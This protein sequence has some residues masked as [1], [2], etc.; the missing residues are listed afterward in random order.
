MRANYLRDHPTD[1]EA[2]LAV[3][4]RKHPNLGLKPS[5]YVFG[6]I[7]DF[8]SKPL[9]LVVELDGRFHRGRESQDARRDKNLLKRGITTL[10]FPS[11]LV[12][13]DIGKIVSEIQEWV[14]AHRQ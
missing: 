5:I 12:F 4:L 6:Y 14:A 7:A 2:L 1:S 8:Y 3:E 13:R 10:R 11:S 9:D